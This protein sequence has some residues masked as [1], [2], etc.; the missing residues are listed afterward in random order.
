M[1]LDRIVLGGIILIFAAHL[2]AS[3]F[4]WYSNPGWV[5]IP[6][7]IAGGAWLGLL[8]FYLFTQRWN[9]LTLNTNRV[10]LFV[11][12]VGFAAFI[13]LGWE[14]YEYLTNVFVAHNF[15]F[16]GGAPGLYFDTLKDLF[17]DV[18]GGALTALWSRRYLY[19]K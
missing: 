13:G 2:A 15:P 8:F 5:D 14:I 1:R 6:I 17:D 10:A 3:I 11:L 12:C 7:H 4:G 18:I 19:S 16:G 9:I